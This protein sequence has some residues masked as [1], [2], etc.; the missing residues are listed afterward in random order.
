MK[1]KPCYWEALAKK[2]ARRYLKDM[3]AIRTNGLKQSDAV[4]GVAFAQTVLEA[5][6]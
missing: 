6:P 2:M 4:E 5:R 3:R 1:P